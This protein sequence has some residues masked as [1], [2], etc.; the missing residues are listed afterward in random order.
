MSTASGNKAESLFLELADAG[1][2]T[3]HA[4][5]NEECAADPSLRAEVE[6][7]LSHHDA[8]NTH[9]KTAF[10]DSKFVRSMAGARFHDEP[11]LPS[12]TRIG[13]Y[14]IQSVVGHGGMGVVY[15]AHQD[16]PRRVVALKIIRRASASPSML[17]RF[18]HEAEILGRLQHPGIAQ[19]YEAGQADTG[20]G[21]QPFIAMEMVR[22]LP[23]GE[24][25]RQ[26]RIDWR[27]RMSLVATTCDAIQHAHQRGIIHRDLKPSNILV[28]DSGQPKVL[29]F[30]VAR[31]SEPDAQTL[32]LHT[33]VGE[34]I[35]TLPYMSP[36]QVA[37]HPD[38]IDIRSDVY[39]LG[40]VL[41]ELLAERL[42][43]DLTGLSLPEAARKVKEA[44]HERLSSISRVLRG[45]VDTIVSKALDKDKNRR[46][47]S[48][49]DFAA[50]IRRYLAG[51]PI[52]AKADSAMYILRKQM[53]R[54]RSVMI[55]AGVSIVALGGFS[56]SLYRKS[57]ENA[58]LAAAETDANRKSQLLLESTRQAN[59]E[60]TSARNAAESARADAVAARNQ[61]VEELATSNIERGRLFSLAG[62]M[63]QAENLIWRQ[64]LKDP[65]S[66]YSYWALCE[67][68]SRTP[69]RATFRVH[70]GDLRQAAL[71]PGA[72]SIVTCSATDPFARLTDLATGQPRA[73]AFGGG[74]YVS[75]I[76]VN[77]RTGIVATVSDNG[78]LKLWDPTLSREL[79]CTQTGR[80]IVECLCFN[81]QG[82][83]LAVGRRDGSLSLYSAP[84]LALL[85]SAPVQRNWCT[86][87]RFSPDGA[88]ILTTSQETVARV[89]RT[90][91]LSKV[92]SFS[93][94]EGWVYGAA[95]SPDGSRIAT[96]G[97]DRVVRV[98]S[99][100]TGEP[101]TTLWAP[102]GFLNSAEWG[103][104]G[105]LYTM[106]WS[107]LDAW[108]AWGHAPR[109]TLRQASIPMRSGPR[110]L[111]LLEDES[112]LVVAQGS[113]EISV[114]DSQ[115][116]RDRTLVTGGTD[117]MTTELSPSGRVAV[118]GDNLGVVRL[119]DARAGR[120]IAAI[121][122]HASRVRCTRFQPGGTILATGGQDSVLRFWDLSTGQFIRE[123]QNYHDSSSS[124]ASFSPD[125]S[126]IVYGTDNGSFRVEDVR[127]GR[128]ISTSARMGNESISAA[129]SPDGNEIYTVTRGKTIEVRDSMLNIV[130][131]IDTDAT[132][133][134]VDFNADCSEFAA[135]SWS[136]VV[137]I[138]STGDGSLLRTLSGHNALPVSVAFH[139]H[140]PHLLASTSFDGTMRLWD[141]DS[142]RCLTTYDS[143][144]GWETL[145]LNFSGAGD[146]IAVSDAIGG[147][148]FVH[149]D[150]Y[151]THVAGNAMFEADR[152]SREIG[153]EIKRPEILSWAR[154]VLENPAPARE[155]PDLIDPRMIESWGAA[156]LQPVSSSSTPT[157]AAPRRSERSS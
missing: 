21:P 83:L 148:T 20:H 118:S 44:D 124:S 89:W 50:D 77:P 2:A 7:L 130:R 62:N 64:H 128:I 48:A 141:T 98:W 132:C 135:G 73:E 49:A 78:Q 86:R 71:I 103:D 91:D 154:R 60:A 43:Y 6:S 137:E 58:R 97:S 69:C 105:T 68:Y 82:T 63:D 27:G 88:R 138:R 24:Y 36:E 28:D 151:R 136:R 61:A 32:T 11:P 42:P 102:N 120:I 134:T 1:A 84:D 99:A 3:R 106:G 75:A 152:F 41:Y 153:S 51:E 81:P 95:F 149:L 13:G 40:V 126:R 145:A 143:F 100:D 79:A 121:Q 4:R 113:G 65:S 117:R 92:T 133:W 38:E 16:K 70:A 57:E 85:R 114:W 53:R 147:V 12:E 39:S 108:D 8:A 122:A 15:L 93:G 23:M 156:T 26:R 142:Q 129:Y 112:R 131:R 5:L 87:I 119:I 9:G 45:D 74:T 90:W 123:S 19:I 17:R 94:H 80:F 37:G 101:L 115:P 96:A 72:G 46:Y 76:A 29:D 35:G 127:T 146:I 18:E 155:E 150:Y 140:D 25:C 111:N 30:G 110:A 33:G 157:P 14:R 47:Q 52:M 139:K 54:Y 66:A 22:G 67:I 109:Q 116:M 144:Q 10:L 125:G 56:V 55:A 104:S 107:S 34:L 31:V 59:L